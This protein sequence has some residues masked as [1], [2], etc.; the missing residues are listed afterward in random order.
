MVLVM[1]KI[2]IHPMGLV[3]FME[4]LHENELADMKLDVLEHL[5]E[6]MIRIK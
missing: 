5:D 4:I 3:Y 1:M 6:L 2:H